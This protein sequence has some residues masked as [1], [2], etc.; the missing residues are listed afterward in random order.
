MN[1]SDLMEN[2][3]LRKMV[4]SLAE[5]LGD[6]LGS[7]VLYGSAARGDFQ[8]ATSDFNLLVVLENL[9]PSTLEALSPIVSRWRRQGQPFPRLFSPQ[10]I[11]D[12]ADVF[13]IE[14]LDIR[15]HHVVLHGDDPFAEMAIHRDHLRLQ[16]E[17][18]LRE[19][20]MR[21]R[22]GYVETQGKSGAVKRLLAESYPTFTALFRGCLHLLGGEVPPHNDQVVTAFCTRAELD[23]APFNEVDRL[24]RGDKVETDPKAL[25]YNY[26]E[27]LTKAVHRVDRF[28]PQKDD[29]ST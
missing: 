17:R 29:K 24:K 26:Y 20:M 22:E 21:L 16:C 11:S 6:R 12:S 28:T 19:K 13:P 14:F 23:P 4:R 2:A 1:A 25:F 8:K 3:A 15:S 27:E 10:L 9:N 5:S 18:E 7:V